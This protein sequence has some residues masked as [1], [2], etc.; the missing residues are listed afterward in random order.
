MAIPLLR[1]SAGNHVLHSPGLAKPHKP[2][3]RLPKE[4]SN[5]KRGTNN[6]HDSRKQKRAAGLTPECIDRP[7]RLQCFLAEVAPWTHLQAMHEEADCLATFKKEGASPAS[8][9]EVETDGFA[10]ELE[11][12]L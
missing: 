5:Q 9:D 4:A 12:L 6:L 7:W 11:N 2:Q 8:S 10:A 1:P 3:R